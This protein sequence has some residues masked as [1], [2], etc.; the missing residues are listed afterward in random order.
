MEIAAVGGDV[1]LRLY[2]MTEMPDVA[3]GSGAFIKTTGANLPLLPVELRAYII[4]DLQKTA[5]YI[6]G[7]WLDDSGY[8]C[9]GTTSQR[10]ATSG[11]GFIP[12][13]FKFYNTTTAQGERWSGAAWVVI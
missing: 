10:D 3:I 9:V 13:G 12:S 2:A 11:S 8:R 6:T 1:Y 4:S 7:L 5:R